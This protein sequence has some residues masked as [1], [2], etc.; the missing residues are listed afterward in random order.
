MRSC[1]VPDRNKLISSKETLRESAA[2][3]SGLFA[4]VSNVAA[5]EVIDPH[6]CPFLCWGWFL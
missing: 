2:A 6:R 5:S 3:M 4:R 1:G